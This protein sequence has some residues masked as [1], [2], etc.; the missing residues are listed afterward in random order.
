MAEQLVDVDGVVLC[1]EAFG[2][3]ADP[4]VLLI[5]GMGSSMDWWEVGF[6]ARLADAGRFVIR[7]DHRDTGRSTTYPPGKPD[8]SFDELTTDPLHVLDALGVGRAHLIG[9]SMGGGISQQ[10]A[11]Q[12]PDRVATITLVA[13]SPGGERTDPGPLPPPEPRVT[14]RFTEPEPDWDDR[15]AVVEHMVDEQR[16]YCGPDL[17]DEDRVRRLVGI[18]LDRSPDP[19]AA[20]NH[21]AAREG[22]APPFRLAEITVPTLVMHGTADPLLPL[23]HGQ[24]LA[25]G[26]PGA[27]L[28]VLDGMGHEVPPP[29]LWDTVVPAI[30]DHTAP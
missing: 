28:V 24:A 7:Y 3:P 17:F 14:A 4:A 27:T 25:A 30:V 20:G 11:V 26:I 9:L 23:P 19:A 13:T 12:H 1:A 6:C 8:Y 21:S 5:S 18:V 2:D 16:A 29:S 22:T 10:L 15:A